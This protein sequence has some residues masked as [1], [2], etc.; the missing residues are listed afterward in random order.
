MRIID[1]DAHVMESIT[2]WQYL[3]PGFYSKRP[4][5]VTLPTDTSLG[6]RNSFWL[7]DNKLRQENPAS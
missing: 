1:A 2:T 3:D 5:P 4:I 6:P 7:I